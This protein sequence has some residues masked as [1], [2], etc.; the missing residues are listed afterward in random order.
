MVEEREKISLLVTAGRE[1]GREGE[2]EREAG[3]ERERER[4]RV[5]RLTVNGRN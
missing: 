2:G 5:N 4:E 1:R 3:R